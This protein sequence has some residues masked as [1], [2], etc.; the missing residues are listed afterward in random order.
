MYSL[1]TKYTHTHTTLYFYLCEDF[2]RHNVLLNPKL[3]LTM[4]TNPKLAPNP[5]P[6]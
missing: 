3:T 6:N 4:L 5:K 2:H 1:A